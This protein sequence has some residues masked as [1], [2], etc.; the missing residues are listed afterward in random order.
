[1]LEGMGV[2]AY[3]HRHEDYVEKILKGHPAKFDVVI[4]MLANVIW[5]QTWI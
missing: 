5:M 3:N 2:K 4:E 1:M